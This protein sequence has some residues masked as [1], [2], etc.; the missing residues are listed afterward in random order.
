MNDSE[1]DE[2]FRSIGFAIT[3]FMT[4]TVNRAPESEREF[5]IKFGVR[6]LMLY[7]VESLYLVGIDEDSAHDLVHAAYED[8]HRINAKPQ[9]EGAVQ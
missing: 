8:L 1:K 2:L 9:P 5:V 7:A 4:E 6:A 3:K